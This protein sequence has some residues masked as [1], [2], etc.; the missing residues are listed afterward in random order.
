MD[1]IADE[2]C[3][4]QMWTIVPVRMD[5][6]ETFAE[7]PIFEIDET[8]RQALQHAHVMGHHHHGL[9]QTLEVLD[10]PLLSALIQAV[11]RFVEQQDLWS[12]GQHR[13]ERNQS[14]LP[15]GQAMGN[16]ICKTFQTQC[17]KCSFRIRH[18]IARAASQ[19]QRSEC[20]VLQ[21]RGAKQ[22]IIGVLEQQPD[23]GSNRDEISLAATFI[24]VGDND[25]RVGLAQADQN[26]Q[27]CRLAGTIGSGQ[28][29]PFMW[30]QLKIDTSKNR[31]AGIVEIDA[32]EFEQWSSHSPGPIISSNMQTNMH[33]VRKTLSAARHDKVFS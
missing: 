13:G 23:T 1:M 26:L 28:G 6:H 32:S 27:E 18:G 7:S 12:H 8:G 11:G 25:A 10:E 30:I 21:H 19:V 33:S 9:G 16:T 20:N 15:G 2:S 5:V 17:S 4:V 29:N 31:P 14:L 24:T 3:P 22:L